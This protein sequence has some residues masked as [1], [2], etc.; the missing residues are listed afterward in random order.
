MTVFVYDNVVAY[1]SVVPGSCAFG[2][3]RSFEET[4]AFLHNNVRYLAFPIVGTTGVIESF[5]ENKSLSGDASYRCDQGLLLSEEGRF[6]TAS[7]THNVKAIN[8]IPKYIAVALSNDN[9]VGSYSRVYFRTVE[10][11]KYTPLEVLQTLIDRLA[12]RGYI[13]PDELT[14]ETVEDLVTRLKAVKLP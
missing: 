7:V 8:I 6:Y 10:K 2:L 1:S 14:I 11:C 3:S 12:R 13:N 4:W 9:V 5:T